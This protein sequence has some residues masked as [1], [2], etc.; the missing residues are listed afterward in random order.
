MELCDGIYRIDTKLGA[1]VSSMYVLRG[2]RSC[3]LFDVGI[4]GDS[5]RT[6]GPYLDAARVDRRLVEW[7]MISHCD[8][9]HFGGIADARATFPTARVLAHVLDRGAITDFQTYL[10]SRGQAFKSPYGLDEAPDVLA[11]ARSVTREGPIDACLVGGEVIDLGDRDAEILHVPGHSWGHLAVHD[12]RTGTL[13]IADAALGSAVVNADGT[14][15][16]PPTYRHVAAYRASVERLAEMHAPLLLTG[17]YPTYRDAAVRAFL[18]DSLE[19]VDSL[20]RRVE[21]ALNDAPEGCTLA[22]LVDAVNDGFG[23]WPVSTTAGALAF[24]VAGHVEDLVVMG[25]ATVTAVPGRTT[26]IRAAS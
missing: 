21:L 25:R 10:A 13:I 3:L 4:D 14:G 24:P 20:G 2:T 22:Q 11:W 5:Y 17:H 16:F 18:A 23:D 1:R 9:D 6:V 19:F 15:A 26:M 7:I 8:V 12:M